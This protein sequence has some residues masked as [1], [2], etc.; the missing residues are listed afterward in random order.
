VKR[1]LGIA[2]LLI[3]AGVASAALAGRPDRRTFRAVS[4][5]ADAGVTDVQ[6]AVVLHL[7][8]QGFQ[9]RRQAFPDAFGP[10]PLG[11]GGDRGGDSGG[12]LFHGPISYG[13]C[14]ASNCIPSIRKRASSVRPSSCC[15]EAG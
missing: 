12:R 5:E 7:E 4:F 1:A 14:C 6:R 8:F 2:V 11:R 13:P 10:G 3:A 9:G 15:A